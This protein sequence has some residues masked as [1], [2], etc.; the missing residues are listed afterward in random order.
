MNIFGQIVGAIG[1]IATAVTLLIYIIKASHDYGVLK[2]KVD[3]MWQFQMRRAISEINDKEIG[4]THSPI[5]FTE[6]AYHA[7][8]AIRPQLMEFW[9]KWQHK[10]DD[11]ASLLAIEREFGQSLLKLVCFPCKLTHGACLILALAVAK[12]TPVLEISIH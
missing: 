7:L 5:Q 11:A 8:E 3:T 4:T 2:T 9:T 10:D 1:T 6:T 12:Q